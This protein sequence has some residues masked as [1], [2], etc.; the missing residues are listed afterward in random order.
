MPTRPMLLLALA[1]AT[2]C[3]PTPGEAPTSS[4]PQ[5]DDRS[6]LTQGD[7]VVIA[8]DGADEVIFWRDKYL[9]PLPV[10]TEA[11]VIRDEGTD[12]DRQVTIRPTDGR[13]AD[14]IGTTA[15]RN[16]RPAP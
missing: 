3:T 13:M 12:P 15:R 10:T 6:T 11:K 16:L 5:A 8:A 14:V 9:E 4:K 2:G 1:L 7:R